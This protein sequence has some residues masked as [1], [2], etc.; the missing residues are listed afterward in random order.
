MA[1]LVP[2]PTIGVL[3][4]MWVAPGPGGSAVF[5]F[6][7]LWLLSLPAIWHIF[8]DRGVPGWSPPLRGGLGPGLLLGLGLGAAIAAA[9]FL[10]GMHWIDRGVFRRAAE[11]FGFAEPG[12]YAALALYTSTLNAVLEEYVWRWFLVRKLE[13]LVPPAAA[14]LLSA[15]FFTIHHVLACLAQMP[16]GAAL[17]ASAGVF[18]GGLTWSYCFAKYRSIWPGAVSHSLADLVI[19]GL[20]ALILFGGGA[21]PGGG[22]P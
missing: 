19:F 13:L 9:Y 4:A 18:I 5:A 17:L 11:R 15:L 1:L 2:A 8:V 22:E 20:G 6:T 21:A 7:K 12:R 14:I 16:M 10:A 3:A